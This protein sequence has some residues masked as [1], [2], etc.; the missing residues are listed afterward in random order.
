VSKSDLTAWV[1]FETGGDEVLSIKQKNHTGAVIADPV[2]YV[3]G[4]SI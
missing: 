1:S 4:K 2:C 3:I